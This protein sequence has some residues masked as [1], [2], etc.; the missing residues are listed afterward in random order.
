VSKKKQKYRFSAEHINSGCDLEE[1]VREN[2]ENRHTFR[3]FLQNES[4]GRFFLMGALF[5]C[6]R[7]FLSRWLFGRHKDM[8]GVFLLPARATLRQN[9]LPAAQN[10]IFFG[11][12]ARLPLFP[13]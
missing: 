6:R 5:P 7:E 2:A 3:A 13:R 12:H 9:Y 1:N 11:N 8:A 4:S 10:N